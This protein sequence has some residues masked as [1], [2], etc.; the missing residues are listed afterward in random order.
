MH[1]I[2]LLVGL[3]GSGKSYWAKQNRKENEFILCRDDLRMMLMGG[4]YGMNKGAEILITGYILN[5]TRNIIHAGKDSIILD[6]TNLTPHIRT[7]YIE[8]CKYHIQDSKNKYEFRA[9]YFEPLNVENQLSNR[10]LEPKGQ[11]EEIWENVIE[12]MARKITRPKHEEGFD[13][14]TTVN[15]WVLLK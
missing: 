13:F 2:T 5:I 4:S 6:Q 9:V 3:P 1:T 10:M 11:S 14:I 8:S 12:N 15:P 7:Q